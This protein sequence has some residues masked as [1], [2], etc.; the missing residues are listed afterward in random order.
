MLSEEIVVKVLRTEFVD[1]EDLLDTVMSCELL[2][3]IAVNDTRG[4]TYEAYVSV[5]NNL[6]SLLRTVLNINTQNLLAFRSYNGLV[7]VLE[8]DYIDDGEF[9][10]FPTEW[11][12]PAQKSV[13]G[14]V[15]PHL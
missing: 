15:R 5:S 12:E 9:V 14:G 3:S 8:L 11:P 10:L 1:N 6:Q 13:G 4:E 2:R 7:E